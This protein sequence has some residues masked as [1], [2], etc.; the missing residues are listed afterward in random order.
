MYN[1]IIGYPL[2]DRGYS[3]KRGFQ[4]SRGFVVI[5]DQFGFLSQ[6]QSKT[7]DEYSLATFS[8]EVS[9]GVAPYSYQWKNRG[10]TVGTNSP[11]VSFV[12]S[13]A[14]NGA[15]IT[16]TVTDSAGNVITSSAAIL[17]V[18]SYIFSLDGVT[19]HISLSSAIN[20]GVG[21]LL[22]IKFKAPTSVTSDFRHIITSDSNFSTIFRLSPDGFYT[23]ASNTLKV[24]GVTKTSSS[25]YPLDGL[26]HSAELTCTSAF[27]MSI[28]GA[29]WQT[30]PSSVLRRF[31]NM[32]IGFEH[33]VG[34]VVV[35]SIPLNNKSLGANQLAAVGSVNAAIINYNASGWVTV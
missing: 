11:N 14:D 5:G 32:L 12:A 16:I 10:I 29:Q 18:T 26:I 1:A 30:F 19:Q 35:K 7:V 15:S 23:V 24:D 17:D 3:T 8:C 21:D 31:D 13:A 6:P 22:R 27:A 25:A 9:G 33:V 4:L 2:A 28:I 20:V 34:G